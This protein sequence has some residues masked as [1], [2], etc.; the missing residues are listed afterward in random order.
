MAGTLG[1]HRV[2]DRARD[3][4]KPLCKKESG[5]LP[6]PP[7]PRRNDVVRKYEVAAIQTD[8]IYNR[9]GDH[10]PDGLILYR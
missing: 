10:D 9:Y 2:Y 7:C 4:L 3:C 5:I 6:L 1:N 8:L